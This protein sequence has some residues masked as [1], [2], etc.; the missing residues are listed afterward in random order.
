MA[1]KTNPKGEDRSGIGNVGKTEEL[2][3]APGNLL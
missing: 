3:K 1:F 2:W